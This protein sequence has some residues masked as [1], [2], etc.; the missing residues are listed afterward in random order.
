MGNWV[1]YQRKLLKSGRLAPSREAKIAT[2]LGQTKH[3]NDVDA[4]MA[5][6]LAQ[7]K[8]KQNA[9]TI[10]AADVL[11]G[12]SVG[13]IPSVIKTALGEQKTRSNVEVNDVV[14]G[15]SSP[16]FL[17]ARTHVLVHSSH[18][19]RRSIHLL[20]SPFCSHWYWI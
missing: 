10:P 1:D 8:T 7:Q 2:L 19:F 18:S 20:T 3:K 5:R 17:E 12:Y 4:A 13:V 9:T 14:Y 11:Q 6:L 16:R 15:T